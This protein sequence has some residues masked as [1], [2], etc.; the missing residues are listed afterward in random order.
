MNDMTTIEI[1]AAL[2]AVWL[3]TLLAMWKLIDRQGRPG[4]VKS[5]L[6]K[7]TLMLVHMALLI[8]GLAMIITGLHVFD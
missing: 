1:G 4:P 2:L 7:E 6:A 8:I 3:V 5:A